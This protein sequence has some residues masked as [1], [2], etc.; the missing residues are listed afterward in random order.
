[1]TFIAML[2]LA[3]AVAYGVARATRIPPVPLLV[4]AGIGLRA[5]PIGLQTDLLDSVLMLGLAM[6]MFGVGAEL[7][8]RRTRELGRAVV[9]VGLGQFIGLGAAA[10]GIAWAIG[11]PPLTSGIVALAAAASSSL[12]AVRLLR[13]NQQFFE[14][15]GRLTLGVL[16]VQTV[17]TLVALSAFARVDGGLSAVESAVLRSVLLGALG[18]LASRTLT[19]WL[20]LRLKLDDET[21][22]IGVLALLFAFLGLSW[23]LEVPLAV[24][25]FCAGYA[26]SPFPVNGVIR[27]QLGS[28]NDFF[29]AI[30]FTALGAELTLPSLG[31]LGLAVG[32]AALVLLATPLLV[33]ALGRWAGLTSLNALEAGLLMAQTSEISLVIALFA[34]SAGL[35]D[36]DLFAALGLCAVAT[37]SATPLIARE[38]VAHFLLQ[39]HPFEPR[40][41]APLDISDHVVVLGCGP[42]TLPLVADLLERE[43]RV[44]VVDD[45]DG[46]V[47]QVR[48][49]GALAIRGDAADPRILTRVRAREARVVLSTLRRVAHHQRIVAFA[50]DVPVIVRAFDAADADALRAAGG[51]VIPMAEVA[52]S[53]FLAWFDH[54]FARDA[55]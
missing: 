54:R 48:E 36:D 18:V 15:Y 6:L 20:L 44:A 42:N 37:M 12:I 7:D 55:S 41:I 25:A 9:L 10:F 52:A 43:W 53:A 3:A 17:L 50:G 49:L 39:I 27:S 35:V 38:R 5:A 24:G 2:L 19:P 47:Q 34:R 13:G 23:A 16:L 26:I 51:E 4:A 46:V 14:P 22:L 29:V 21:L 11:Y 28:L 8:E 31:G 1:V 40:V 30:F 32:L 45:D 33:S